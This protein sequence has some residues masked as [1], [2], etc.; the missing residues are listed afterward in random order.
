M[1]AAT[2]GNIVTLEVCGPMGETVNAFYGLT[3][4]VEYLAK[5]IS[6]YWTI[7][8]PSHEEGPEIR[9]SKLVR[10]D[11]DLSEYL[12][13]SPL[14][15]DKEITLAEWYKALA[16]EHGASLSEEGKEKL[17]ESI[18]GKSSPYPPQKVK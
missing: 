13:S 5:F 1:V 8:W 6:Q 2:G 9:Y 18:S 12:K 3:G 7:C 16:F 15:D 4:D 14:L 10:L 17:I 11:M